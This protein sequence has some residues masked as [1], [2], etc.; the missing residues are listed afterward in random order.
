[1][2]EPRTIVLA[3]QSLSVPALPLR[4]NKIAYP[5]CRKLTN[6]GLLERIIEAKGVLDCSAEEMEDLAEL[7]FIAAKAADPTVER[8]AFDERPVTPPELLDVFLNIRYQTG[9]WTAAPQ[10]GQPA[11]GEARGAKKPR[12]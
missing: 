9:G 3:G 8:E 12:K 5:L 4:L 10:E 7:A 2:T 11:P 1:M 6:D